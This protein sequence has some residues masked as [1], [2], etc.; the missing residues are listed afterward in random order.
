MNWI[1]LTLSAFVLSSAGGAD[2]AAFGYDALGRLVFLSADNGQTVRFCYDDAG[3]RRQVGSNTCP[4]M[5]LST[6]TTRGLARPIPSTVTQATAPAAPVYM[7]SGAK[8]PTPDPL[9]H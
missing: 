7:I 6:P 3:N 2:A 1:A 8:P 4:A 5:T 9:N